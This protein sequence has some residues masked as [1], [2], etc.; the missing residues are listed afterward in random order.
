MKIAIVGNCQATALSLYFDRTP[1]VEVRAVVDVNMRSSP[2]FIHAEHVV[3][4]GIDVDI[5]FTQPMGSDFGP[6]STEN[7]K[8][9][10][11]DRVK[12]FTNI[13]FSGL[14]PDITYFGPFGRRFLSPVGDYHSR[15]ALA[16]YLKGYSIEK[17]LAFFVRQTY[18]NLG[19]IKMFDISGAELLKRDEGIDIKFAQDFLDMTRSTLTLYSLNHPTREVIS[20]LGSKLIAGYSGLNFSIDF[21][22]FSDVLISNVIWPIYTDLLTPLN[23]PYRGATLFYPPHNSGLKPMTLD[24]FVTRSFRIYDDAGRSALSDPQQTKSFLDMPF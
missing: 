9:K 21:D 22:L 4:H 5:I 17:C 18:E 2:N 11:G 20:A 10:F 23:L 14:H 12:T 6:I 8:F 15:I 13:Y 16:S 19:M 24:E 1:G 7:L 3:E